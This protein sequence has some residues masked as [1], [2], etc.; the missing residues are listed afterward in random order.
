M[1][2]RSPA[3]FLGRLTLLLAGAELVPAVCSLFYAEW[4]VVIAFLI[5]SLTTAI[6]GGLLMAL[7][8]NN[9]EIYRR[10]GMLIVVGGWVWQLVK[11]NPNVESKHIKIDDF[12]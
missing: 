8:R 3:Q 2:F 9:G 5:A 10:E 7:G 4:D 11:N 6:F 12:M 1:N